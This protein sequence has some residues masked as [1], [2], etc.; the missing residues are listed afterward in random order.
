MASNSYNGS[1]IVDYLKS[2]GQSSSF[3]SR[4]N[5]AVKQGIV[6]STAQYKGTASQNTSLLNKLRGSASTGSNPSNV[7]GG[8]ASSFI[9]SR[10]GQDIQQASALDQPEERGKSTM[11]SIISAFQDFTGKD[12]IV[13]SYSLPDLPNFEKTFQDL[14]SQYGIDSLEER[15]N[16]L[17]AEE[18][19]LRAQL[20]V[21]TNTE[22][23]KPVALNVI[24]GRV[25]EQERNFMERIDYVSRQKARAVNELSAANDSIENIMNFRKMDYD[26]AKSRYDSEFSQ[27][28]Q[29]FNTIKGLAEFEL[30]DENRIADNAR[31]NL[32]IIY[33]SIKDGGGDLTTIDDAM[34]TKI[35]K[36]EVQAGLPQGFYKNIAAQKPESEILSTTTRTTGGVKYAD[37]LY[38]N[39]DGS[40]TTQAVRLGS[41]G[42]EG[43]NELSSTE[44]TRAARSD[45]FSLLNP[46]RGSD[47]YVAPEDYIAVRNSWM[48]QGLS[49]KDFDESFGTE[50]VNP[51]SYDVVGLQLF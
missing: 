47:G 2:T 37:V 6:S 19:D 25:G 9:N 26:S 20:R 51:E 44:L 4:A 50:F 28:I 32:Q 27:N 38:R 46:R 29:L 42:S 36:L 18:E 34:V 7:G 35:N 22:I 17:D 49:R 15:V 21:N 43:S 14:R 23:G 3:S 11:S 41:A 33:N 10:Q 16:N 12:S 39:S 48:Q 24:E 45:T 1:S 40:I 5:L 30:N 13:P 31:A 8:D